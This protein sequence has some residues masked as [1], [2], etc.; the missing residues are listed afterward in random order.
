MNHSELVLAADNTKITGIKNCGDNK[1]EI[2]WEG[3]SDC[4]GYRI[5]R[6]S[7]YNGA[8]TMI[9]DT[10]T[11]QYI[12][13]VTAGNRY[14]YKIKSYTKADGSDIL[15]K[16][17]SVK[18]GYIKAK[19]VPA[20]VAAKE[21]AKLNVDGNQLITVT[22]DKENSTKANVSF[23]VKNNKGN[24]IMDFSTIGYIG[25]NG[26]GKIKEGDKKTPTGLYKFTTAF[27]TA[28]KP[29]K[30]HIPYVKVNETHWL[31]SDSNSKYYNMF[32]SASKSK[33]GYTQ[34]K[35]V[36]K[37]WDSSYGEQLY[38]YTKSYKYSL[39]LNYNPENI[40]Y[41]GSAIFLHCYTQDNYTAGCIAIPEARMKY[42]IQKL[43]MNQNKIAASIIID[44]ADNILKY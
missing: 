24:W 40:P 1:L 38:K 20:S 34:T 29:E 13:T 43:D 41:K 32:V 30:I 23:Y 28:P 31:V 5:Y 44:T 35:D 22:V 37:D 21:I 39:I 6:S 15:S 9:K 14:Y 36:N 27:G 18:S 26:I 2:S 11:N 19:G 12:D 8:Y 4:D 25:K 3:V 33:D 17:S 42:L 7:A 10:K 16:F